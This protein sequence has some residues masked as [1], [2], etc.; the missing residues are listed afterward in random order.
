MWISYLWGS[1]SGWTLKRNETTVVYTEWEDVF[2]IQFSNNYDLLYE[3]ECFTRKWTTRKIQSTF[4]TQVAEVAVFI[5]TNIQSKL[6]NTAIMIPRRH[7]REWAIAFVQFR[8]GGDGYSW[9]DWGC[10]AT[11]KPPHF[12]TNFA[13]FF[14]T[15]PFFFSFFHLFR[16]INFAGLKA[17]LISQIRINS[18]V[19]FHSFSATR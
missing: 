3:H 12:R 16:S 14:Q 18:R 17:Q 2:I 8:S 10:V 13:L 9:W 7:M 11:T 1:L 19:N 15:S 5:K 6:M 4:G